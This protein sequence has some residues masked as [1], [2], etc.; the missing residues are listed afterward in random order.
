MLETCQSDP[1]P[2]K[3]AAALQL[4][5]NLYKECKMSGSYLDATSTGLTAGPYG[6][7]QK[8]GSAA[9]AQIPPQM[10]PLINRRKQRTSVRRAEL[11][12]YWVEASAHC[13]S[14]G[15][16]TDVRSDG[17]VASRAI[18]SASAALRPSLKHMADRI[19]SADDAGATR[20][21][22]PLARMIAGV[23][24]RLF[25]QGESKGMDGDDDGSGRPSP[26]VDALRSASVKFLEIVVA[27][28]STRAQPGGAS[29][30]GRK[31][32][33]G[34][35]SVSQ[36]MDLA[37][38]VYVRGM[39]MMFATFLTQPYL[40]YHSNLHT[41]F[42]AVGRFCP[43]RSTHRSP[44]HYSRGIRGNWRICIQYFAWLDIDWWSG[45]DRSE[46]FARYVVGDG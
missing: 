9:N 30:A 5:H 44:H 25:V 4:F 19:S 40:F 7:G 37:S 16:F 45:E 22:K 24:R 20:L 6:E 12:R 46:S 8:G 21:Y 29:A 15:N 11:L 3:R 34:T 36:V 41:K 43:G 1:I 17:A 28:F 18:L 35:G 42:S 27:C 38:V 32:G 31:R 10:R 39:F 14:P 2:A 26:E 13:T 23:L 33:A